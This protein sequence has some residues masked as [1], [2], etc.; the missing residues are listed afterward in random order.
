MRRKLAGERVGGGPLAPEYTDEIAFAVECIL[1]RDLGRIGCG[2]DQ[3]PQPCEVLDLNA[4]ETDLR[5]IVLEHSQHVVAF[6]IATADGAA[7]GL[8]DFGGSNQRL[9]L[10]GKH[11]DDA[12]FAGHFKQIGLEARPPENQ[13][14]ATDEVELVRRADA[15]VFEQALGPWTA[16]VEDAIMLANAAILQSDG[17]IRCDSLNAAL[18]MDLNPSPA[19]LLRDPQPEGVV[20]HLPIRKLIPSPQPL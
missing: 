16:D 19:C 12:A 17:A 5:E 7:E 20:V 10:P 9:A 3:R 4:V 1:A 6:I 13:V 15:A 11:E 8:A 18:L 2:A 14:A